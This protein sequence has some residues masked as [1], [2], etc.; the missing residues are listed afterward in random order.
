MKKSASSTIQRARANSAGSWRSSQRP[1]GIIHCGE[2]LPPQYRRTLV[3]GG[4]RLVRLGVGALVHPEERGAERRPVLRQGHHRAGGAVVGQRDDVL[5]VRPWTRLHDLLSAS[6][7]PPATTPP[8]PARPRRVWDR[9]WRAVGWRRPPPCP[10]D[11]RDNSGRSA[12][13]R[14][15]RSG[16]S[17]GMPSS[18]RAERRL[19]ARGACR[20]ASTGR[21]AGVP[22]RAVPASGPPAAGAAV[23]GASICASRRRIASRPS[24]YTGCP[25]VVSG[26]WVSVHHSMSS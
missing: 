24:S 25:T 3:A 4:R 6:P 14:P 10:P 8:G 23:P 18:C 26:G 22:E 7:P 11:R 16:R 20:R 15:R 2:T 19:P 17:S 1:L 5:G 9:W 13:R 21:P 12:C